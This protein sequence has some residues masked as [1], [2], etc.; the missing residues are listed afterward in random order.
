MATKDIY[1]PI[2]EILSV[3]S[4]NKNMKIGKNIIIFLKV[5]IIKVL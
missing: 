3:S 1:F 2:Q 5:I 4:A